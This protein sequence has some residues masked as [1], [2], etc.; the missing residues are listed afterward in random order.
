MA[1]Q[2]QLSQE[3]LVQIPIAFLTRISK[4]R[5]RNE[6][7]FDGME[8]ETLARLVPLAARAIRAPAIIERLS[9]NMTTENLAGADG[10]Q[11]PGSDWVAGK[12]PEELERFLEDTLGGPAED[13]TQ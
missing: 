8:M 1:E 2:A 6:D 11:L 3:A 12:T 5:E 13:T 9:R 7:P 10:R 4:A